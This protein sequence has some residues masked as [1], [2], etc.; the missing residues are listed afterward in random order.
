[1]NDQDGSTHIRVLLVEDSAHDQ[2]A[3]KRSLNRSGWPFRLTVCTRAEEM[4]AALLA[5]NPA[6]DIV[7]VDYNLPGMTGL[8]AYQKLNPKEALPPFVLLTGAGSE[9]LAV[10]AL[11]AGMA[12]YIIKDPG[13]GYLRLLPLKL[14]SAKQRHD[15]RLARKKAQASLKKAHAELETI[16]AERTADLARTV[17]A[18]EK[19]NAERCRTEAALR[20]SH[21]VLRRLSQKIVDIQENERRQI[22]TELHDSIGSSLAA[23]KFALEGKLSSMAAA[24]PQDAISLETIVEHLKSTIGEVRRISS[25][26]RPSTLDDLGLLAT[27]EWFCKSTRRLYPKITIQAELALQEDDIP[28][29]TKIVIYR[30]LQEAVNNALKHSGAQTIRIRLD[31]GADRLH[32]YVADDGCGFDLDGPLKKTD[33]LSGYGMRGMHD[34]AEMAGGSLAVDSSSERGTTICLKLPLAETQSFL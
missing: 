29:F 18:L 30:V 2:I 7:V 25:N 12:D 1:M 10:Q 27:I 34:R 16:V 33:P 32:L 24:A 4:P 20:R 22:A 28:N 31:K 13:Q 9:N 8:E 11:T 5:G 3:F 21:S 6:F 26:L 17:A 23:I 19:E 14:K 15:D